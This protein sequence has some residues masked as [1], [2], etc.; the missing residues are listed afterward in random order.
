MKRY[1]LEVPGGVGPYDSPILCKL[2][3]VQWEF[4]VIDKTK[5]LLYGFDI[6][7]LPVGATI[8]VIKEE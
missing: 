7:D 2:G 1:I 6:G 8:T 3:D 4:Y 5:V